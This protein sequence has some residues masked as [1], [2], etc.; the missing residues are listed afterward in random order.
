APGVTGLWQVNGR[1]DTTYAQRVMLDIKY[2]DTCSFWQDLLILCRTVPAVLFLRGAEEQGMSTRH[3]TPDSPA[4][5]APPRRLAYVMSRFPQITENALPREM[6]E[7]ERLGWWVAPFALIRERERVPH[8]GIDHFLAR[9]HFGSAQR[10]RMLR[11]NLATLIRRPGL[12]ARLL[13]RTLRYFYR[14]PGMLA[15]SL[16]C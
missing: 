8:P 7:L 2:G 4:A 1:T 10:G 12:Y 16:I 9:M 15:R 14:S 6:V 5:A 11:T 13:G 3:M